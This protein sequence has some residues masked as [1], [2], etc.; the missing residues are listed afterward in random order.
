MK[1]TTTLLLAAVLFAFAANA[2]QQQPKD[3]TIAVTLN[4]NQFRALMMAIDANIDSKKTSKE[5]LEF[6]Q[7]NASIVNP[8]TDWNKKAEDAKKETDKPKKQ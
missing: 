5:I 1:K 4:I 6:L 8:T 3:T 2:Q 7:T